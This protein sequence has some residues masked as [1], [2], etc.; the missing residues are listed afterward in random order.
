M[1][2]IVVLC[3]NINE[4]HHYMEQYLTHPGAEDKRMRASHPYTEVANDTDEEVVMW[5]TPDQSN[6]ILGR[7]INELRYSGTYS[8][9]PKYPNAKEYILNRLHPPLPASSNE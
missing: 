9:H 4:C 7:E 8:G 2:T 1:K 3:G 5:L 6:R